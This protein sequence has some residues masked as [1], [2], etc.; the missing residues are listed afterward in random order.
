MLEIIKFLSKLLNSHHLLIMSTCN[1]YVASPKYL[2]GIEAKVV[3]GLR[4]ENKKGPMLLLLMPQIQ[5]QD[6]VWMQLF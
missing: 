1:S 5:E 2:C 4:G 3:A 6:R